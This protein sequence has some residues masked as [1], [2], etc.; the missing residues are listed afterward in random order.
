[1][2]QLILLRHGQS[3]WNRDNIFTG[4]K[5]VALSEQGEAEACAAGQKIKVFLAKERNVK[6]G[7]VF[8]SVLRRA[9]DTA[10]LALDAA[11]LADHEL[12][13]DASLNERR[14]GD[15]EGKNKDEARR[16]FGEEQVARWRRSYDEAP[17]GGESLK[18]TCERVLPY[19]RAR[20]WP[21]VAAGQ[22][23][24]VV[25]H[26]NSLRGLVKDIE[27]LS[28]EQIVKV[29]V[30]TGVPLVYVFSDSGDFL[31]KIEL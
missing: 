3:V 9:V 5:D 17:P 6:L 25:A 22:T 14:Y 29:E 19:Y 27:D 15:L 11:G 24:L 8:C 20:I 1:M 28:D 26:G 21:L 7:P 12:I 30:P 31:R 18:D 16:Q 10:K 23:I 13:C 2:G 4:W